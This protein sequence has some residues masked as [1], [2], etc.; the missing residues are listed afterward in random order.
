M[1][2]VEKLG[3][4]SEHIDLLGFPE[5]P[6]YLIEGQDWALMDA[7]ASLVIPS[8]LE[9]F[10]HYPEIKSK[11]KY[12]ILTHS[13]FDHTGGLGYLL[14]KFPQVKVIASKTTAEVFSKPKAVKYIKRTNRRIA[15]SL[16]IDFER[17]GLHQHTLRVDRVVGEGDQIQLGDEVYLEAHYAPGHSRCSLAYLLHPEQAL[18]SGEAIG[19]YNDQG[20]I[21]PEALSSFHSYLST[22]KK[23]ARLEIKIICL[24]HGGVLKGNEVKEYFPLALEWTRKFK[25]EFEERFRNSESDQKIIE[26]MTKKYYHGKIKLQPRDVFIDN[27]Q[28]MLSAAKRERTKDSS[29]A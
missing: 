1:V 25:S 13:H 16:G 28:A 5:M 3:K 27:L 17:L 7:G 21:L 12:I 4:I 23:L 29:K 20:E 2:L 14:D 6:L 19:F 15:K 24:P 22:L 26:Q 18:F 8:L 10:K 11:L 9:Q